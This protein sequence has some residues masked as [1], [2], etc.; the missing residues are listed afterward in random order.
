M[1]LMHVYNFPRILINVKTKPKKEEKKKEKEKRAKDNHIFKA[2]FFIKLTLI[3][4][5]PWARA[6]LSMHFNLLI[7][8]ISHCP[9][10]PNT[11]L[12]AFLSLSQHYLKFLEE[13]CPLR[14]P[15]RYPHILISLFLSLSLSLLDTLSP[16]ANTILSFI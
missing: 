11:D 14:L 8:L 1:Q 4:F 9:T 16:P 12:T 13:P 6:S 2:L 15:H 10:S 5:W 7:W 3:P